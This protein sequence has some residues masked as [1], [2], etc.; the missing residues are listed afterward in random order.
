MRLMGPPVEIKLI[1]DAGGDALMVLAKEEQE[2]VRT[3]RENMNY[4]IW[5]I[6]RHLAHV[7]G[8]LFS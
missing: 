4:G 2:A 8:Y 1:D 6:R 5:G 3:R 7:I